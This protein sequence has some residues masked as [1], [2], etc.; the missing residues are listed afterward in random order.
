MKKLILIVPLIIVVSVIAA[1]VLL[2]LKCWICGILILFF[3]FSL[4]RWSET[5]ALNFQRERI[6]DYDFRIL[7]YNVN[8][9]HKISVN[10]GTTEELITFIL[11]QNAD[12][13]LLQEYNADLYPLIQER[14]GWEY[15]HA[16]GNDSTSRFKSV[17]SRFPIESY[18]QFMV[19]ANNPEYEVFQNAFYCKKKYEDK[20]ILPICK[21]TIRVGEKTLQIFNCHLMSNNFTVVIRNLRKK[22]RSAIYGLFPI[23]R[24]I[25]YG[26]EARDVQ[27]KVISESINP[28]V[29]TL[30]CGDM[31]DI[32]GSSP[33]RVLKGCGL[34]DAWWKKGC[35]F[36]FTFHGLGLR[37]RLDH[38]L[39]SPQSLKLKKVFVLQNAVSD[40]F[41]LVCDFDFISC[42]VIKVKQT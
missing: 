19:N 3:A 28:I 30:V 25:D 5:F 41:P 32:S 40:H 23:M 33:L 16:C 4:N 27:A 34:S 2:F 36:G 31:N 13:V 9:A 24:R 10:K 20:E 6:R 12:I 22:R 15:Q 35:G 11:E 18:E 37:L 14:L 21:V 38:V 39:F 26:Y 29:P 17:F 42:A 1:I 8:R 7:T